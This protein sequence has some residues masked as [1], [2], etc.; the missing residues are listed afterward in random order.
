MSLLELPKP[1]APKPGQRLV[2][3]G[4]LS[5]R[6][7]GLCETRRRVVPGFGTVPARI[8]F[9]AQSPGS[10]ENETG[11]PLCG[12]S[13]KLLTD[14]CTHVGININDHYK[15][16]VNHCQPPGNRKCTGVEIRAC[17]SWLQQEIE[18]VDPDIIVALGDN[19]YKVF[20][21][22]EKSPITQIRGSVFQ[23][24][25]AGRLRYVVPT[26]HPAFVLRNTKAN[27]PLLAADLRKV[28][29]LLDGTHNELPDAVPFRKTEA[30]WDEIM[31]VA[32]DPDYRPF[33]FDLETDSTLRDADI[34]GVGVCNTEGDGRY[35]PMSDSDEALEKMALLRDALQD[36]KREKIVSNAKFEGH[37]C[38]SRYNTILTN[39]YDTLTEAWLLGGLV[40]LS[41]KD[42]VHSLLG[43]EMIR[44]DKF[45]RMGFK[46][47]DRFGKF[48]LSMA[49]AQSEALLEVV[50]Y[51]AQDPD[52]SLRLHNILAPMLKERGIWDLYTKVELPFTDEL[53][54]MERA[55][56][57]LDNEPLVKAAPN[58]W[59]NIIKAQVK[60]GDMIG[61]KDFNPNSPKQV[62]DALYHMDH[63]WRLPTPKPD[64]RTGEIKYATDKTALGEHIDN[65]LVRSILSARAMRKQYGTYVQGLNKWVEPDGRIHST[66]KQTTAATGRVSSADPNCQNIPSRAREDIDIGGFDVTCVRRAFVAP[67]GWKIVAPDLSQVEVRFAAHLSQDPNMLAQMRDPNGDVHAQ[68]AYKIYNLTPE[69]VEAGR[70]PDWKNKRYTSKMTVFGS[71][72]GL[73][74]HGLL[75]RTPQLK[76]T[77]QEADAY[78]EG[79]YKA[80]PGLREWQQKIIAFVRANGYAETILGRRRYFPNIT[81]SDPKLRKEAENAAINMPIQ[82]SAADYFKMCMLAVGK[83]IRELNL[84]TRMIMQVHDEIVMEAPDDE[85]EILY[86]EVTP[87]MTSVY[88]PMTVPMK[89]DF[90]IGPNW[91]DLK[92]WS[93]ET[94]GAH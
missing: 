85:I 14:V 93:P 47:R 74:G 75:V 62:V 65:D 79:V 12:K 25:I 82:G 63:Q 88:P 15:T 36:P 1:P 31:E 45:A 76:L 72:Y 66:I 32:Y 92:A 61:V 10:E 24:E 20:L 69:D 38:K 90:E 3:P 87:L 86:R 81:A 5:C 30:T 13:G 44:I 50:E 37:V 7:C 71:F 35:Y 46:R 40:P 23:R 49:D 67:E 19:A 21:P 56:I 16:N 43:I 58:L 26:V 59:A 9:V 22:E 78:I 60:I 68:A 33:G 28:R 83:R 73:T 64:K 84:R 39:Y 57:L 48:Q 42:A 80:F 2:F 51:A 41:L 91:A 53:I 8:L 77:I 89:I 18:A 54:S 29:D 4:M 55:G 6:K 11:I 94:A 34:V 52:A 17:S 27:G 70:V